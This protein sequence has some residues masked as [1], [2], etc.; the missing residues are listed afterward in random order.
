MSTRI[1]IEYVIGADEVTLWVWANSP[2]PVTVRFTHREWARIERK[3]EEIGRDIEEVVA[4]LLEK[5]IC[6]NYLADE[7]LSEEGPF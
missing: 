7:D 2:D 6:E 3:A 5:D 1:P 4:R